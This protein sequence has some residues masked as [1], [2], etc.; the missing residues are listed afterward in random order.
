MTQ[1]GCSNRRIVSVCC[2][3]LAFAGLMATGGVV[4]AEQSKPVW[5]MTEAEIVK[6]VSTAR[7]G[8]QLLQPAQWPGGARVAVLFSFDVDNETENLSLGDYSIFGD[9]FHEYGARA[10]LQRIVDVLDKHEIPAS[11]F[12]PVMS[13]VIAPYQAPI[14]TKSGRHEIGVHGWVH[15]RADHMPPEQHREMIERAVD[16]WESQTGKKPA[17]YRAPWAVVTSE[18]FAYV[19]EL[20][21]LYDSSMLADDMPYEI[22]Y[23]G[24]PSGLVEVPISLILEDSPLNVA[25]TFVAGIHTPEEMFEIWKS[26]FDVALEEGTTWVLVAHPHVLGH[27]S[28]AKM[29]E[30]LIVHMKAT[31][32]A[33]FATHEAVARLAA[34]QL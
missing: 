7:A 17:G 13:N 10:G 6:E 3:P 4:A 27:R 26:E 18:T 8:R 31:G 23:K 29:L 28:R 30:R 9:S 15:A 25:T 16:Y 32:K 34:E 2:T 11:F 5:Q 1:R 33:W 19:K 21:F 12:I 24:E 22:V 14:I 20:G